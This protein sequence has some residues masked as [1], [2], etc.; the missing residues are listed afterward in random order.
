MSRSRCNPNSDKVRILSSCDR[1]VY[2]KTCGDEADSEVAKQM[3]NLNETLKAILLSGLP[4]DKSE[5]YTMIV[6]DAFGKEIFKK[7]FNAPK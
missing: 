2:V 7:T 4:A 1:P 3:A 5:T 6:Q